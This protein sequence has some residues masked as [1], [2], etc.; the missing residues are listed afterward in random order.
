VLFCKCYKVSSIAKAETCEIDRKCKE[1]V[2][3]NEPQR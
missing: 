1:S 2:E 3:G